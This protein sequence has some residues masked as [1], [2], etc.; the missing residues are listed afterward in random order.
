MKMFGK[1]SKKEKFYILRTC[2]SDMSAHGGFIWP[3]KGKVVCP[4]WK[5]NKDCGNGLHGLLEGKGDAGYLSSNT[6]AKWL[7]VSTTEFNDLTDKV[8]FKECI[9]E[10]CGEKDEAISFITKK[11]KEQK[12]TYEGCFAS[13]TQGY[14]SSATQ[15]YRSSATQGDSSSATQGSYSSATQGYRSSA[16]QGSYSSA[17][18]GYRSSR[19]VIAVPPRRVI[20]VPPRRVIQFRHA[21]LSQFRHAG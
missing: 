15:G 20:A 16:T 6:D 10:F 14:R 9:V 5:D 21:G 12:K 11:L 17:T 1:K 19:R 8:K 4:D 7:V 13:A 18:Q 2:N 3:T